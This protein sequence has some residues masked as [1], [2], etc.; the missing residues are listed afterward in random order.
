MG[1]R[2]YKYNKIEQERKIFGTKGAGNIFKTTD[3]LEQ[4]DQLQIIYRGK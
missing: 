1:N 2:I 3:T 4:I